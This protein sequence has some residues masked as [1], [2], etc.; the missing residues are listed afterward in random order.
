M[1]PSTL[2]QL[3][4]SARRLPRESL[5][6]VRRSRSVGQDHANIVAMR[7]PIM[8]A[9]LA[10][11]AS[12]TSSGPA[13]FRLVRGD[14]FGPC[15]WSGCRA[16][17]TGTPAGRR[18]AADRGGDA[19]RDPVHRQELA[20]DPGRHHQGLR[21]WAPQAAAARL[22]I[23]SA[24]RRPRSPVQALAFPELATT[25]RMFARRRP[26]AIQATGAA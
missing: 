18:P 6:I 15:P 13:N 10:I 2:M 22:A 4:L 19:L 12:R 25:T 11:P 17:R 5:G 21:G 26:R 1:C 8:P 23:S 16:R 24:S 3:K 14:L 9:P 7:G 20:D